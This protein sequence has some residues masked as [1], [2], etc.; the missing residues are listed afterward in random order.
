M[1]DFSSGTPTSTSEFDWVNGMS[2]MMWNSTRTLRE[3]SR[4]SK[5]I[6]SSTLE[7]YSTIWQSYE[8]TSLWT[9]NSRLTSAPL[10]CLILKLTTVVIGAGPLAGEKMPLGTTEN[11]RTSLK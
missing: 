8:W 11:T 5:S 4:Y 2:T 3:T 9:S 10:A 1:I 7:H 6:R